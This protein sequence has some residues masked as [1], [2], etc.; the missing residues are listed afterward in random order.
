MKLQYINESDFQESLIDYDNNHF[1][2]A[3]RVSNIHSDGF[4]ER[5]E[6]DLKSYFLQGTYVKN[7]TLIKALVFGGTE[8]TYQSWNGIE[9]L[10]TSGFSIKKPPFLKPL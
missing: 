10:K 8:K 7:N 4:I 6:S 5:A 1:E 9:D 3:G 2:L